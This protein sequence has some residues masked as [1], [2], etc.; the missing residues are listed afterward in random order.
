MFLDFGTKAHRRDSKPVVTK[1]RIWTP[2]EIAS[3]QIPPN[4]NPT[5]AIEKNL[6]IAKLRRP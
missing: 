1:T 6:V 2:S 3:Y 5:S 4:T